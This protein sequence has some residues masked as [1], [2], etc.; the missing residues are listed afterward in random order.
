VL[1]RSRAE[2]SDTGL[3]R[4]D[5][6]R[7]RSVRLRGVPTGAQEGLLQQVIEK[8]F[9]IRRL[10]I[11]EDRH[12]AVVELERVAVR[13]SSHRFTQQRLLAAAGCRED[14]AQL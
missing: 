9:K 14:A 11:F 8:Q 7:N 2:A 13:R 10:E 6:T 12:E 4:K 1:I 3:S 5:D